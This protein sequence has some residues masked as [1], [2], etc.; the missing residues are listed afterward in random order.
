MLPGNRLNTTKRR[1]PR[2]SRTART[3]DQIVA[4]TRVAMQSSIEAAARSGSIEIFVDSYGR[5]ISTEWSPGI[6]HLLARTSTAGPLSRSDYISAYVHADDQD[7]VSAASFSDMSPARSLRY[8]LISDAGAIVPVVENVVD[9]AADSGGR[10]VFLT[11]Q[12]AQTEQD[13]RLPMSNNPPGHKALAADTPRISSPTM[14]ALFDRMIADERRRVTREIHDDFGQLLAAMKIDLALLQAA[15]DGAGASARQLDSINELVDAMIVSM[16]RI[17]ANLPP[18]AIA[19]DGLK[20]AIECMALEFQKRHHIDITVSIPNPVCSMSKGMEQSIY[21]VVQEA[22]NNIV[23]HAEAKNA[24]ILCASSADCFN[25]QITDDGK[26]IN[27]A[28]VSKAGSY[29]LLW[30]RERV[31]AL[32]GR[33]SIARREP[34][35]TV[36][37]IQIPTCALP[38]RYPPVSDRQ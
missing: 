34:T 16:R 28:D 21:R 32:N 22:L 18:R 37:D 4:E 36:L 25:M 6:Y 17:I 3:F 27:H 38:Q 29:G 5:E 15:G 9:I 23:R 12:N 13:S 33:M 31:L 8:R 26:G 30:M 7:S 11:V 19:D 2:F 24:R 20:T 35:G 10:L 1:Q 14:V